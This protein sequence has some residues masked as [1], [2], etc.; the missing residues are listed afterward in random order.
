VLVDTADRTDGEP[1]G[2]SG[3]GRVA[4]TGQVGRHEIEGAATTAVRAVMRC[5]H[6]VLTI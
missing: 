3:Q 1:E 4:H 5:V 2:V 6:S